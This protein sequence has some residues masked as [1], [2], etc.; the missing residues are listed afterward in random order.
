MDRRI[1]ESL[2]T[3]FFVRLEHRGETVLQGYYT[4]GLEMLNVEELMK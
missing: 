1:Q 4:G 2:E 3:H